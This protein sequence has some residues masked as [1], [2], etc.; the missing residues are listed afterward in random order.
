MR[1]K[2]SETMKTPKPERI[3]RSRETGA[4]YVETAPSDWIARL[5]AWRAASRTGRAHA[6]ACP[7]PQGHVMFGR[8]RFARARYDQGWQTAN[9]GAAVRS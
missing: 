9:F 8:S 5:E 3:A 1:Q 4:T 6:V 2:G 7:A